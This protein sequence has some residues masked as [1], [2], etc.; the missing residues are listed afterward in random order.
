MIQSSCTGH[1][2]AATPFLGP[3]TQF[4]S[5]VSIGNNP[6][7]NKGCVVAGPASCWCCERFEE[8]DYGKSFGNGGSTSRDASN[9]WIFSCKGFNN[10]SKPFLPG[11]LPGIQ[12]R[13]CSWCLPSSGIGTKATILSCSYNIASKTWVGVKCCVSSL[14][15]L[16]A[17]LCRH[18]RT[19]YSLI[20]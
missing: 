19:P 3:A 10:L 5:L 14:F 1:L 9:G 18:R 13:S 6:I 4:R 8:R 7:F 11:S 17:I 16:R 12:P 2:I 20:S 15:D